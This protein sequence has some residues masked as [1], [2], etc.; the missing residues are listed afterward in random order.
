MDI[1]TKIFWLVFTLVFVGSIAYAYWSFV[2]QRDFIIV[3]Q[4]ECDPTIDLCFYW[5]CDPLATEE[6]EKCTG[7]P[8]EDEW[9]YKI[10]KRRAYN[11]RDCSIDDADCDAFTCNVGE[12]DCEEI[13]CTEETKISEEGI[14]SDPVTYNREHPEEGDE[15]LN[16]EGLEEDDAD[17]E[18][19]MDVEELM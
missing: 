16:M 8:D 14:C 3:N 18:G 4:A 6:G 15:G 11:V 7:D 13:F 1:K 10:Q 19:V 2:M 5:A 17:A 12:K 9:Y